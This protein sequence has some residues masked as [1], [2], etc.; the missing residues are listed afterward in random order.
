M[1]HSYIQTH[2]STLLEIIFF[3]YFKVALLLGFGFLPFLA[4]KHIIKHIFVL[5]ISVLTNQF[6]R[7]VRSI[8]PLFS[9]KG[10]K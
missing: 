9:K 7:Q 8:I 4:T 5:K 3:L 10:V 6:K 1:V 2:S